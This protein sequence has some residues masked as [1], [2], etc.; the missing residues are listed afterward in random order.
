[1][2]TGL[3]G[4]GTGKPA[5]RLKENAAVLALPLIDFGSLGNFAAEL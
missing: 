2:M 5:C 4:M 3:N 1:M